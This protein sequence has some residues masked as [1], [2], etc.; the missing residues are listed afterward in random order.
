MWFVLFWLSAM[1]EMSLSY[2]TLEQ[3]SSSQLELE[4][5]LIMTLQYR[6]TNAISKIF[7]I[8]MRYIFIVY[9]IYVILCY[10]IYISFF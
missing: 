10:V 4:C 1:N 3:K 2:I 7:W 9:V 8:L 6:R 5:I